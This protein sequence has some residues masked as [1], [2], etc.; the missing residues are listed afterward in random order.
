MK[1]DKKN[2][3]QLKEL[4]NAAQPTPENSQ[5]KKSLDSE[6]PKEDE[7][8]V[9][10][11]MDAF[12]SDEED[13][14]HVNWKFRDVLGGEIF[15]AKWFRRRMWLIILIVVFVL[16]YISN[17]YASQQ[18]LIKIDTLKKELTDKR[19]D[20]LSRSSQL[21]QRCRQSRILEYLKT[22]SDSTMEIST[23][24]PYE[25]NITKP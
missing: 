2:E 8:S 1:D 13:D 24:P 16:L 17:R 22:T 3:E 23:I 7:S 20:A 14:M 9:M 15:N 6:N 12:T 4:L 5:E 25:I 10:K 18:E 11:M 19:Y 21:L